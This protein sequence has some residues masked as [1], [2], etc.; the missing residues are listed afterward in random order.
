MYVRKYC[1]STESEVFNSVIQ[2]WN[3]FVLGLN[4]F[5]ENSDW[6]DMLKSTKKGRNLE[7]WSMGFILL[8]QS[9][10]GKSNVDFHNKHT[11]KKLSPMLFL[12]S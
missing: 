8:S 9:I 2:I 3:D 6:S 11:L 10:I 7:F 12:A 1:G 4:V 5:N